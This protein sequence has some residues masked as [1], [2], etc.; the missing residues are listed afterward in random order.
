MKLSSWR[1]EKLARHWE[2]NSRPHCWVQRKNT[3]HFARIVVQKRRNAFVM[4]REEPPP[5]TT[6]FT[7]QIVSTTGNWPTHVMRRAKRRRNF[8][9]PSSCRFISPQIPT[10]PACDAKRSRRTLGCLEILVCASPCKSIH[11]LRWGKMWRRRYQA[12]RRLISFLVTIVT[13]AP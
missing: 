2:Q 4:M 10:P 9:A 11:L 1:Q 6:A 5:A 3:P 8:G 7:A 13:S 12:L